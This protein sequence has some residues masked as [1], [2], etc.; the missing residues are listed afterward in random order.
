MATLLANYNEELNYFRR[1]FEADC[2]NRILFFRGESGVGKTSLLSVCLQEIKAQ[3]HQLVHIP[4]QLRNSSVT[5]SEIFYRCGEYIGWPRLNQFRKEVSAFQETSVVNIQENR[6]LGQNQ[7]EVALY[8]E[9]PADRAH[10]QA[11]LTNAWFSDLK[12]VPSPILVI[13]DTYEDATTEVKEWIDGPFLA[14]VARTPNL[15][16]LLAGQKVPD[17]N[18]IEWGHCC[19]KRDLFGVH[20]ASHWMPVIEAM[21]RQI[22]APDP[23]SWMSGICHVLEGRP[24]AIMQIIEQLP[25]RGTVS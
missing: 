9:N 4:I 6:M 21:N 7:I 5:V 16:V 3:A 20:Q 19:Q 17:S 14:R 13:L 10:R 11:A 22:E 1:L 15:R 8:A 25:E 12:A 18:N 23:L 2:R 24:N